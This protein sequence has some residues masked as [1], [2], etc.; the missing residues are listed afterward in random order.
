M[1]SQLLPRTSKALEISAPAKPLQGKLLEGRSEAR[2]VKEGIKS[3][4]LGE[5]ACVN[6]FAQLYD[7]LDAAGRAGALAQLARHFEFMSAGWNV[8]NENPHYTKE[9]NEIAA[10]RLARVLEHIAE[11]HKQDFG[12]ESGGEW[13]TIGERLSDRLRTIIRGGAENYALRFEPINY[14][15]RSGQE[16]AQGEGLL[17]RMQE[18]LEKLS[19]THRWAAPLLSMV[20]WVDGQFKKF[21]KKCSEYLELSAGSYGR[22]VLEPTPH[23]KLGIASA[24]LLWALEKDPA[25]LEDFTRFRSLLSWNFRT[26]EAN[27]HIRALRVYAYH[28]EYTSRLL[29]SGHGRD[30][31]EEELAATE[32]DRV[33]IAHGVKED[34][35]ENLA[36]ADRGPLMLLLKRWA[37]EGTNIVPAVL[38][39]GNAESLSKGDRLAIVSSVLAHGSLDALAAAAGMETMSWAVAR[40]ERS[41]L[42]PLLAMGVNSEQTASQALLVAGVS[43]AIMPAE[44][45]ALVKKVFRNGY[46]DALELMMDKQSMQEIIVPFLSSTSEGQGIITRVFRLSEDKDGM[47]VRLAAAGGASIA[48][49][50]TVWLGDKG[51]ACQA[52]RASAML[53]EVPDELKRAVSARAARAGASWRTERKAARKALASIAA[54]ER[55]DPEAEAQGAGFDYGGQDGSATYTVVQF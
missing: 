19:E 36:G 35:W 48:P 17:E 13:E 44:K 55:A 32:A 23:D 49:L 39:A 33:A 14:N 52:L 12:L 3:I 5:G 9:A 6:T 21:D 38:L 24:R 8:G 34:I 50:L 26:A 4:L 42:V 30:A 28:Q 40:M 43:S 41:R 11:N 18:R 7:S 53:G 2:L 27:G 22:H 45:M 20:R 37:G 16:P 1:K 15:G 10:V 29:Q 54:K 31:I 47:L 25:L 51:L 46:M